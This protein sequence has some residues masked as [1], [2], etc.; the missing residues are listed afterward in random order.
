[1]GATDIRLSAIDEERFGIKIARASVQ[2]P[3]DVAEALDF[4]RANQAKMIIVRCPASDLQTVQALEQQGGLLMDTL[5]YYV[6]HLAKPPI[7]EDRHQEQIRFIQPGE[8]KEIEAIA[9]L[10]FRGYYGHYHADPRLD[11]KKCDETYVSWA[12]NSC[13]SRELASAMLVAEID[14]RLAGFASLRRNNDQEGEGVLFG[15]TPWAQ[16]RGIYRSFMIQSMEWGK[17]QGYKRMFYSTQ[18]TNVAVQKVWVRVGAEM[19]HAYYTFHR[20]FD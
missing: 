18:V 1:M 19:S 8:E 7:P 9:A 20:W 15:V 2:T 12:V 5:L 11:R 13:T 3:D 16:G 4:C 6:R 17:T 10:S 14:G